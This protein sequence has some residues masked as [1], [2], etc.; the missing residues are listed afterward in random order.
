M[1]PNIQCIDFEV[2]PNW[3]DTTGEPRP[4]NY[5]KLAQLRGNTA[6]DGTVKINVSSEAKK[7]IRPPCDHEPPGSV[8]PPCLLNR[9]NKSLHAL[10]RSSV[11]PTWQNYVGLFPQAS[12]PL[13]PAKDPESRGPESRRK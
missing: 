4:E 12:D 9:V 3:N 1:I 10:H 8:C 7:K 2:G 13:V 11:V 5:V 6:G